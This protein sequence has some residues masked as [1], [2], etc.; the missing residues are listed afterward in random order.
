MYHIF[1]TVLDS[2]FHAGADTVRN[3]LLSAFGYS[4]PGEGPGG[5]RSDTD[6][7]MP[8]NAPPSGTETTP[9]SQY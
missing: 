2:D 1:C 9:M 3:P 7:E 5:W 4:E 6:M 8:G